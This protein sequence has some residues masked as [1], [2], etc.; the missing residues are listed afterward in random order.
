MVLLLMLMI[1]VL[2]EV[3]LQPVGDAG[4]YY[5]SELLL[6]LKRFPHFR[7]IP[8]ARDTPPPPISAISG[9]SRQPLP[10]P[11]F[12]YSLATRDSSFPPL[13]FWQLTVARDSP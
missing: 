3:L 13:I 4:R 11:H 6:P 10:S 2:P 12:C 7:H 1:P 8:A 5:R 9:N